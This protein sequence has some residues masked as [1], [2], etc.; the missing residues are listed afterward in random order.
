MP[1]VVITT[2]ELEHYV[3][4]MLESPADMSRGYTEAYDYKKTDLAYPNTGA[5]SGSRLA[6]NGDV[7]AL[8]GWALRETTGAAVATVRLRDGSAVNA[9][10]LAV[11]GIAAAGVNFFPPYGRG[12]E[13]ATG[14]IFLEVVAGSLE[15][16]LYWR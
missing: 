3:R 10:V 16:V 9:E 14:K 7:R 15:G 1:V 5:V 11:I 12:I 8:G 4:R 6:L 2:G 13:V